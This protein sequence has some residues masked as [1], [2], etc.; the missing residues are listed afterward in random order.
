M[1]VIPFYGAEQPDLF[2]IERAAMD[3]PGRL[4]AALDDR[5]PPGLILDVGAGDGFTAA[6]LTSTRR[7]VIP[8]EP[9]PGM[10]DTDR[11]LPWVQGEAEH[12]PFGPATFA[13]A[14]AT[15]AYF[16]SRNW[17]PDP[18]VGE[19]HRVVRPGGPLLIAENLGNDEFCALADTEITADPAFWGQRGFTCDAI[20]TVFEFESIAEAETLLE[21][22][23]GESGR[24]GAATTL[25]YR[26]GLFTGESMG[27]G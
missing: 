18:G 21:F 20:E 26:I 10:V 2:A 19:L 4:I 1:P 17:D 14:Y 12:L 3:R 16:F 9:A 5:L 25:G 15:W 23:F 11:P 7:T 13:G 27:S 24:T 22:Y 6:A 8:L